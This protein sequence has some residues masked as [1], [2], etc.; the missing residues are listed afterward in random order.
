MVLLPS[1]ARNISAAEFECRPHAAARAI[2]TDVV[3]ELRERGEHTSISFPV[4]VSS[5][6]SV[7]DRSEMP[8]DGSRASGVVGAKRKALTLL[9]SHIGTSSCTVWRTT[10]VTMSALGRHSKSRLR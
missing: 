2:R 8:M 6:G 5:I 4:E 7:A 10:V 9:R 1:G 3:V